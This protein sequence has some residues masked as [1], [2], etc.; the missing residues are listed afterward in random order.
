MIPERNGISRLD[1][2]MS[3]VVRSILDRVA[4]LLYSYN[5]LRVTDCRCDSAESSCRTE[6]FVYVVRFYSQLASKV[7]HT[8]LVRSGCLSEVPRGVVRILR[9]IIHLIYIC[10]NQTT[11]CPPDSNGS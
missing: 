5:S 9:V 8:G 7:I 1:E 10:N 3:G 2:M 11:S 6:R 4:C